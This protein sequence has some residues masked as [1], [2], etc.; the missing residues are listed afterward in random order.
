MNVD[1]EESPKGIV[2][3]EEN[4]YAWENKQLWRI[5]YKTLCEQG[6]LLEKMRIFGLAPYNTIGETSE[7][8]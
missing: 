8:I 2:E 6:E 5:Y 3:L 7:P 1:E 4:Q